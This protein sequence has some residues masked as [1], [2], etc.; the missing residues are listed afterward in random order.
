MR[1]RLL[2]GKALNE[3][4]AIVDEL[5]LEYHR[6]LLGSVWGWAR[7]R[8]GVVFPSNA[9]STSSVSVS[10]AKSMLRDQGAATSQP[11]RDQEAG[12]A[13]TRATAGFIEACFSRLAHLRSGSWTYGVDQGRGITEFEQFRYL[14]ALDRFLNLHQDDKDLQAAFRTDYRI[15]PDITIG[16]IPLGDDEIN[17][18]ES[19]VA[20]QGSSVRR[21]PLRS[22]NAGG[23]PILHASVSCKWTIRS[24]RVQNIRTEALNL[25]RNRKGH[26]PHIVAVTGEPFPGRLASIA[27]GTGDVDCVYHMALD[28]LIGAVRE[29]SNQQQIDTLEMLIAGNR[30]RDISDLPFDLAI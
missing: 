5:R 3:Y 18:T 17:A 20:P 11:V 2:T 23:I 6:E 25:I 29:F 22:A 21:T 24:D 9:D 1:L 28:E 14:E 15:K 4:T 27:Q 7:S 8:K 30:L 13:F 16:R 19:L 12:K 10:I 26:V